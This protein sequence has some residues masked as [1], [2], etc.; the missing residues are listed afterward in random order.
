MQGFSLEKLKYRVW[1]GPHQAQLQ[2][3]KREIQKADISEKQRHALY[4]GSQALI[5]R[6]EEF[7]RLKKLHEPSPRDP[8]LTTIKPDH[9]EGDTATDCHV[10]WQR[11]L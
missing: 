5:P 1:I 8:L 3:K 9:A 7:S 2:E 11:T 6:L 4:V 10:E